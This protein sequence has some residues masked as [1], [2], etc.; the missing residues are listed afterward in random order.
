MSVSSLIVS[1]DPGLLL[2]IKDA[3]GPAAR[4][5]LLA[6][7][8]TTA[9][10]NVIVETAPTETI[11]ILDAQIPRTVNLPPDREE[12]A[13]LWLLRELKER[14][15]IRRPTL[16]ITSRPMGVT[17]VDEYC[18][19]D[20]QAIA[21]P[22]RRLDGSTLTGFV[23]MLRDPPNPPEPTWV[24]IEVEVKP[25]SAKC[26]IGARNGKTILWGESST[27]YFSPVQRL[28]LAYKKPDFKQ[29]WARQIHNDGALLFRDLVISTLGPG[30]F[31]HLER[32]A[33]GLENLAFRYRVDDATLYSAPF[34][35]M[36]RLSGLPFSG[37][38]VDFS[39][40]PFVLVNAPI[41]RR[42][43]GIN[44]RAT[45]APEG[46]PRPARVLFICSQVGQNPA[47]ATVSDTVA[48]PEIDRATG[49]TRIRQA[50]FRRLDNIKR[51]F[52]ELTTLQERFPKAFSI[53]PLDLA[54]D[55]H[56]EGAETVLKRK[57]AD[58]RY[59]IVHFAGHSLT[60]SDLMTLL[61]LPGER[62]G[63]AEGMAVNGFAAAV[64]GTGAR[65]VYLSSCQGSSASTV[66]SLGQRNVPHVLGFRW[67]VEDDRAADFANLFYTE[68]FGSNSATISAAFRAACRGV[69]PK[70]VESTPIWASPILATR[71]DDWTAQ[72]V[73]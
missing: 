60:T 24:V 19:P 32:A 36:V 27:G 51:E 29:G 10:Q 38:D 1:S 2:Q 20:N 71:Y 53:D 31:S 28:A 39:Q 30:L 41:T 35:A 33:G 43:N 61:V 17:E 58:N 6:M 11:L 59:D 73:L 26:F 52:D 4:V 12:N 37:T 21:L 55:R 67:D 5:D 54:K 40:N 25:S 62:P 13:A 23:R 9:S 69:Y 48:V 42:M 22:Q 45:T 46:V 68:L 44:L 49:R 64:A 3:L 70:H 65:L 16:V 34:E 18:T 47:G 72:R 56:P 57:L 8:A 50:E 15:G 7:D 66:A 14:R 63:E